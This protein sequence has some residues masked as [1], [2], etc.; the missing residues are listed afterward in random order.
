[1]GHY[2]H[3]KKGFIKRNNSSPIFVTTNSRGYDNIT[4]IINRYMPILYQ[5]HDLD[6]IL[7][8]G[9]RFAAR[10]AKTLGSI[11]SPSMLSSDNCTTW[12]DCK[13][14]YRCG[15]SRCSIC[16]LAKQTNIFSSGLV[17][18]EHR[19]NSFLNCNSTHFVY[20]ITCT[21]CHLHYIGC[22]IR[23][24]K[25]RYREHLQGAQTVLVLPR[26]VSNISKH[27]RDTHNV[28]TSYLQVTSIEKVIRPKRGE[29][30]QQ[31]IFMRESFWIIKLCSL[32][33]SHFKVRSHIILIYF[34]LAG[35]CH[36]Y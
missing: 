20:M 17:P 33:G 14:F 7:Q 16:K 18:Y 21:Q 8:N 19:I 23:K 26:N 2:L 36:L 29:E 35:T 3:S 11:L 22:T 32:N 31:K 34:F 9:M 25:T 28:D 24:L 4:S 27:F 5:D 6:A 15:H 12:L 10:R 30:W 13:G 1:M